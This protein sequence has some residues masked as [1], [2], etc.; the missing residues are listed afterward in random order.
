[1]ENA[2]KQP[3]GSIPLL[4]DLLVTL[5]DLRSSD[6]LS[7]S[8]YDF[9][10][11]EA[12]TYTLLLL[13]LRDQWDILQ[14]LPLKSVAS[15]CERLNVISSD[16]QVVRS[17]RDVA[18]SAFDITTIGCLSMVIEA[19]IQRLL[20]ENMGTP[21][22]AVVAHLHVTQSLE[23]QTPRMSSAIERIC[24]KFDH[25]LFWDG[26]PE[27]VK[28]C[29]ESL[30]NWVMDSKLRSLRKGRSNFFEGLFQSRNKTP[31]LVRLLEALFQR[32]EPS[33]PEKGYASRLLMGSS[34]ISS[35][36]EDIR[37]FQAVSLLLMAI[38]DS[39][40]VDSVGCR[41]SM[42]L[43]FNLGS[44]ILED[45][46]GDQVLTGITKRIEKLQTDLST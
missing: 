19:N 2:M 32:V 43:A 22:V 14:L 13:R 31:P 20:C 15:R 5:G 11:F 41:E 34:S 38:E 24:V 46:G 35:L 9:R 16:T 42:V 6:C 10:S 25:L 44:Q 1:M 40:G 18:K 45:R 39:T 17:L 4:Q 28:A 37:D 27:T 30:R 3:R 12:S 29:K 33:A 7:Q 8:D 26:K 36:Q 21:L 23:S